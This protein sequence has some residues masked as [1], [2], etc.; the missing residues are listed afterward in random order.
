MLREIKLHDNP[1]NCCQGVFTSNVT[2]GAKDA[3]HHYA[4]N[5]VQKPLYGEVNHVWALQYHF[6]TKLIPQDN[7]LL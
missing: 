7:H 5:D 1:H 6:Q 4:Y 3:D 2:S